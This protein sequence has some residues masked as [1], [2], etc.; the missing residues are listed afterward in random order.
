[1]EPSS[2]AM[3]NHFII[4]RSLAKNTL[5]SIFIDCLFLES[6]MPWQPQHGMHPQAAAIVPVCVMCYYLRVVGAEGVVE[7]EGWRGG[8][9]GGGVRLAHGMHT[10]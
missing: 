5:G 2:E 1:M 8:F 7:A 10:Q 6:L 4:V 9:G 3:C